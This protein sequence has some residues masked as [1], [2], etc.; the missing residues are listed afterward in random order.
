[1]V[2]LLN[3]QTKFNNNLNNTTDPLASGSASG[4]VMPADIQCV[5]GEMADWFGEAEVVGFDF[6]FNAEVFQGEVMGPEVAGNGKENF[7]ADFFQR[8]R[9]Y[10]GV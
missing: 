5:G 2:H 7:P 4:G 3:N 1:M 9:C 8:E 10:G 6:D